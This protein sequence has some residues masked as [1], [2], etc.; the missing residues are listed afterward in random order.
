MRIKLHQNDKSRQAILDQVN[1]LAWLLDNSIYIPI[2]NYRVGLD[3]VFSVIPVLGDVAG[4]LLSSFIVIQ[5]MRLGASRATLMRMV[6]NIAIEALVGA[7][8]G[9]G[10]VFDATYKANVRNAR[11]LHQ[12]VEQQ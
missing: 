6:L 8:P 4:L 7:I 9:L 1:R 10:D 5:A 2:I 12:A 11:L 3:A